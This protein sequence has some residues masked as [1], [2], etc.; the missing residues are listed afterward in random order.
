M[1]SSKGLPRFS[2][3]GRPLASVASAASIAPFLRLTSKVVAIRVLS[4]EEMMGV[5]QILSQTM[6]KRDLRLMG[7]QGNRESGRKVIRG[8]GHKVNQVIR[9]N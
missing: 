6:F 4:Q 3:R 8:L 1:K 7:D 9:A 2:M 5:N